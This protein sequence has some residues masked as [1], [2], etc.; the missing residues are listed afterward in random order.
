MIVGVFRH[1][2]LVYHSA[3]FPKSASFFL[4]QLWQ[5]S[6]DFF[7]WGSIEVPV[8]GLVIDQAKYVN[9]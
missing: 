1:L 2:K 8:V 7:I 3:I 6:L 9:M 4:C 5:V